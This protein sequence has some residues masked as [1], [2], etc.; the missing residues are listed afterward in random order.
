LA[1]TACLVVLAAPTVALAEVIVVNDTADPIPDN[2]LCA[3]GTCTLREAVDQAQNDDSVSVPAGTYVLALGELSLDG[4]TINGAG[5]RS[6]I[7]D[8]ANE[9]RVMSA[10]TSGGV[11]STISGVTIRGG[12]S[13]A[14]GGG[15]YAVGTVNVNNSHVVGNTAPS[16]GGIFLPSG[17]VL[18]MVGSTVAGNTA[19]GTGGSTGGGIASDDE[20]QTITLINSTVS[21]NVSRDTGST[22]SAQGGG[23]YAGSGNILTLSNVTVAGNEAV[24]GGGV[25]ITSGATATLTNTI[26]AENTGGSC[27]GN[28]A[29][30]PASSHH[31]LVSDGGCALT[32]AGNLQGV[33]AQLG[34]LAPNGGPT[35]TRALPP[36]SP[37]VNAGSGCPATDQRG[38]ARPP[39]CD[40]GAFEYVAPTLTVTTT[41]TNNDG[42]EDRPADFSVRVTSG[43]ADV[44]GSPQ[45]GSAAGTTYTLAPGTFDVSAD[46]PNLYT[47][48]LGGSCAPDGT[49]TLGENQAATCTVTANDKPPVAGRSV[50]VL[51]ARG[52]VRIKRP[53]G[54]FRILREGDLLPNGTTIDT[55]KGRVTL[56]VAANRNGKESKAD[57]YDGVFK[58]RQSKD[59]RPTTTLTLTEKLSCPK[60]GNAIAAAKKKK[61]RLWGDGSGKFRTKGKHSAATVVGTKW[62]VEDRCASTL[63]RVARGRVSVRD[64]ELK[65]TVIVRRGKR[66]VARDE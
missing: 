60:A 47:L 62:L 23:I 49:V 58:F 9:D 52:T 65:K 43:G 1:V 18:T 3:Q 61:R 63:T 24:T 40:I 31:N 2:G 20:G 5:A 26:I 32:G 17:G 55:L 50:G 25:H 56:I 27:A 34:G 64:F 35:D 4:D 48:T 14:A 37:A 29:A 8:G 22:N 57:F 33:A 66:Y 19:S 44:A 21:G 13:G 6:T 16:G 46:G 10:D 11:P 53:G 54:R 41:V 51:R 38:V 59:R 7:I 39:A 30:I 45:P 28:V 36:S 12:V 42:G 15:I